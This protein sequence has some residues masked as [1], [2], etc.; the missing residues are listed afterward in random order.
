MTAMQE[1]N[2][3]ITTQNL[4]RIRWHN[5]MLPLIIKTITILRKKKKHLGEIMSKVKNS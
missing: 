5:V 2:L 3:L 4:D 1:S